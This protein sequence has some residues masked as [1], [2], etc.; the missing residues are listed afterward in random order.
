MDRIT[1]I[2]PVHPELAWLAD[3]ANL[4]LRAGATADQIDITTDLAP[5]PFYAVSLQR[6]VSTSTNSFATFDVIAF[7]NPSNP[8]AF[9]IVDG[10][11]PGQGTTPPHEVRDFFGG[12]AVNGHFFLVTGNSVAAWRAEAGMAELTGALTGPP[13]EVFDKGSGVTCAQS[14]LQ[15]A[16]S[17]TVA[18]RDNDP[19]GSDTRTASVSM[20][21][22]PGVL[23]NFQF[24]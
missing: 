23:L 13:C 3:S 6:A 17:I 10:Y 9:I 19:S 5:G 14:L 1:Q 16:F 7:D 20:A 21:N 12:S 22:V 18:R 11:S 2:A 4:V 15:A 8:T 24:P